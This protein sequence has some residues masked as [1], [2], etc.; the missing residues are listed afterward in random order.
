MSEKSLAEQYKGWCKHFNGIQN[1]ACKI[2]VSYASLVPEEFGR[3]R[4]LPCFAS[5]VNPVPC[6]SCVFP[7]DEEAA[8]Y[9]RESRRRIAEYMAAIAEGKCPVC[10][11]TVEQR[12]VGHCVYGSCG[13]RLYQGRAHHQGK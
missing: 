13:H 7:T 11:V 1:D 2:G 5:T 8:A 12:Q 9:E 4:K 3:A 6:V 10:K